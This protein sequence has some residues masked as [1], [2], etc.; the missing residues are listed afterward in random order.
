MNPISRGSLAVLDCTEVHSIDGKW[1]LEIM[2]KAVDFSGARRVHAHVEEFDGVLPGITVV[3]GIWPNESFIEGL[4][5]NSLIGAD[6]P[7]PFGGAVFH[8]SAIWI[9]KIIC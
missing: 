8:D 3:E 9:K 7:E 1:M 5:I 6:S 2:T 4:G